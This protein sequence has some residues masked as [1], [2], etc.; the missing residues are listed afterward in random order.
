MSEHDEQ[1]SGPEPPQGGD[2][3]DGPERVAPPPRRIL[4][5]REDRVL[6]G[7]CGGLGRYFGVDPTLFRVGAVVLVLLG[8]A[9]VL[10]YLAA[11]LLI[12]DEPAA[13]E[14]A[15]APVQGRGRALAIAGVIVLLLV[16]W[17][18]LLGG[19]LLVAGIGVPI[20]F[21]VLVGILVWWLAS[22]EGP[23]RRRARHRAPRR[24]GHRRAAP[25]AWSSRPRRPG[26]RAWAAAPPS[27]PS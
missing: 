2:R 23:E 20:A 27:R 18:I 21:L 8:G 22:G 24:A 9:G 26:R 11:L 4:R 19:G 13:G 3:T 7:V 12:P 16:G 15:P 10:L 1:A 17:P 5:S 25:S 6:A 14:P